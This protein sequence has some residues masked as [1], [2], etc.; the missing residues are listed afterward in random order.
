LAF[1]DLNVCGHLPITAGVMR[2]G[3]VFDDHL[4]KFGQ[5]INMGFVRD[6][7]CWLTILCPIYCIYS[8][9]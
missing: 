2:Q 3:G 4:R 7:C 8:D 1:N 6:R 9:L 5:V